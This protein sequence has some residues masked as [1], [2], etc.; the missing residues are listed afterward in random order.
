MNQLHVVRTR[1]VHATALRITGPEVARVLRGLL[2]SRTYV[3]SVDRDDVVI[4]HR[5]TGTCARAVV[6]AW[7]LYD[8]R[9]H[10]RVLGE[11]EFEEQWE[12]VDPP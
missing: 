12:P 9:G 10:I 2:P 5:L 8:E 3:V 11:P 6:G 4:H 1:E 7:V